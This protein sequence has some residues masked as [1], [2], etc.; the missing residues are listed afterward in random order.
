MNLDLVKEV[1]P[2]DVIDIAPLLPMAKKSVETEEYLLT[3]YAFLENGECIEVYHHD[4]QAGNH[5]YPEVEYIT[6]H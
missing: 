5:C 2:H 1:T 6:R 3:V 4:M